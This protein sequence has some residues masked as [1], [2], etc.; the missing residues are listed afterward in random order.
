MQ[1]DKLTRANSEAMPA[2]D[3]WLGWFDRQP[4]GATEVHE[5]EGEGV[6]YEST[7]LLDAQGR[8][9]V[10]LLKRPIGFLHELIQKHRRRRGA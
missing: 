7:G 2:D 8:P 9:L 3:L 5:Q 1:R 10:R 4:H 6:S